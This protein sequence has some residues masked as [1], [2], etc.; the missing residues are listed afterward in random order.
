M[1][2]QA[3]MNKTNNILLFNIFVNFNIFV[4]E[5]NNQYLQYLRQ[6]LRKILRRASLTEIF[7]QYSQ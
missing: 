4:H 6:Y 1:N 2:Q 3:Y 5:S 7:C